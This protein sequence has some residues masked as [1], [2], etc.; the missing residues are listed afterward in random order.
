MVLTASTIKPGTGIKRRG[1]R[2]GRGNASGKGTYSARGLK[3][4]RSRSGGKS[5]TQIRAFRA[6]LLKVPK[7]RGFKSMY[8]KKETVT[9]STLERIVKE[10]DLVT[11]RYLD[12]KGVIN[13]P[14]NGVKIVA[15]GELKKKVTIKS[16]LASKKAVELIEKSGSKIVF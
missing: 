7:L 13:R 14:V 3:G 9:L 16:C 2:V 10:G 11:P 4:Q 1:K 12:K 15:R 5:R 8:S 6:S